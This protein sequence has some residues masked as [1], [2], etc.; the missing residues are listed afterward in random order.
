MFSWSI[1][2]FLKVAKRFIAINNP[3]LALHVSPVSDLIVPDSSVVWILLVF[4]GRLGLNKFSDDTLLFMH[5][6]TKYAVEKLLWE[7]T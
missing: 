3:P 4:D 1:A 7:H 5:H 6:P 2:D